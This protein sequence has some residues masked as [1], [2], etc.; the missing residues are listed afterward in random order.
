MIFM[1]NALFH[2]LIFMI[3]LWLLLVHQV[4][5]I[6]LSVGFSYKGSSTYDVTFLGPAICDALLNFWEVPKEKTWRRGG[7]GLKKSIFTVTSYVDDPLYLKR[8][9]EPTSSLLQISL[10]NPLNILYNAQKRNYIIRE[11]FL[12]LLWLDEIIFTVNF[13]LT[14]IENF[15]MIRS[16]WLCGFDSWKICFVR[17]H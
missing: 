17:D 11:R 10:Q 3:L 4:L 5:Q 16:E 8:F 13:K 14:C 7:G 9:I 2:I 6:L 1:W 15:F 12:P